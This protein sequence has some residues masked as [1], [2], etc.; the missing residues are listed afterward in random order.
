MSTVALPPRKLVRET[1]GPRVGRWLWL[2]GFWLGRRCLLCRA[3]LE[4]KVSDIPRCVGIE[5]K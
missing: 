3:S 2:W 5:F 1:E 4:T